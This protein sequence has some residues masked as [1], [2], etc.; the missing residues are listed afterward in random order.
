M[1]RRNLFVGAA[2]MAMTL[3]LNSAMAFYGHD[4][5]TGASMNESLWGELE[6]GTSP[7]VTFDLDGEGRLGFTT[8]EDGEEMDGRWGWLGV[9][10]AT[11]AWEVRLDIGNSLT[12]AEFEHGQAAWLGMSIGTF[13]GSPH[14]FEFAYDI[15]GWEGTMYRQVMFGA[16]KAEGEEEFD[17]VDVGDVDRVLLS[18]SFDPAAFSL[19]ADYSLDQG[20]SMER[21]TS[22]D[23]TGWEDA[24]ANGFFLMLKGMA[25]YIV[26]DHGDLY[27]NSFT[28]I[29]EPSTWLL[30]GISLLWF[31]N[32]RRR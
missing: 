3:A 32:R 29:P 13:T 20:M 31:V 16:W 15:F 27:A 28:A 8:S 12:E 17:G 7:E 9:G 4:D 22:Y 2:M 18:I 11:R 23:L 19:H 26:L 21:L 24:L 25:D 1:K 6:N 14:F 5:F 30:F 10:S